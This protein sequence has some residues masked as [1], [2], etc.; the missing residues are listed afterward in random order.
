MAPLNIFE[1]F[2]NIPEAAIE[3]LNPKG[4]GLERDRISNVRKPASSRLLT[5]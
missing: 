3:G 2:W 5:R 4:M 1:P